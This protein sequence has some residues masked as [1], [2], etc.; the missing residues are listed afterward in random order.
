M[1]TSVPVFG[2][3]L[4]SRQENSASPMVWVLLG[5]KAAAEG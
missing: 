5:G 1:N 4:V 3:I 2:E